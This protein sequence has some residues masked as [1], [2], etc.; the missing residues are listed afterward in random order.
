MKLKLQAVVWFIL[1]SSAAACPFA[2]SSFGGG[3]LPPNDAVHRQNLRRRLNSVGDQPKQRKLQTGG[4]CVTEDTYDDI[5]VDISA[6]SDA[7]PNNVQRSHFLG[8]IVRLGE[9]LFVYAFAF[10][11]C[12]MLRSNSSHTCF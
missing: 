10:V 9:L 6:A 1:F 8:A 12:V 2:N 3:A 11:S 7:Q 4:G 5:F